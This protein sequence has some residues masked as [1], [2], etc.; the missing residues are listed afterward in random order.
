MPDMIAPVDTNGQYLSG[1]LVPI[2]I[3]HRQAMP[4]R[5]VWLHVLSS[6]DALLLVRRSPSMV[7]CAGTLS[8]I[9]EHH[10]GRESDNQC[11]ARALREELPGLVGAFGAN[12][13]EAVP[14]RPQPR[15]FLF[16]Y[17]PP[18]PRFDRCLISEYVVHLPSNAS[19]ALAAIRAGRD[20]EEEHEASELFFEPLPRVWHRLHREPQTF[21]APEL[22][23]LCLQET[24]MDLVRLHAH[25]PME[26]RPTRWNRS[27]RM[28]KSRDERRVM[29]ERYD[30]SFVVRSAGLASVSSTTNAV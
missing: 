12:R 26:E 19:A 13:L 8:I 10:S 15:W 2:D 25:T 11:A 14:L 9:G 1:P 22:L 3:V 23:P 30:A 24:V 5:G 21:C 29:P 17:G 20:R 27:L 6:D 4:H 18:R 16:D 7:T 28:W